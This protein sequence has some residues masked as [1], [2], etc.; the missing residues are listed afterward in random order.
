[1]RLTGIFS[2]SLH[3]YQKLLPWPKLYT[4]QEVLSRRTYIHLLNVD[5]EY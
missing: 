2:D 3:D 1:M 5:L 4:Y